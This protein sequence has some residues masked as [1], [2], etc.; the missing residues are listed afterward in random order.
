M[1]VLELVARVGADGS[2]LSEGGGVSHRADEARFEEQPSNAWVI[3]NKLILASQ[4][5]K[6]NGKRS[7]EWKAK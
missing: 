6:Y 5:G 2:A 1:D 4:G 3:Q 7:E